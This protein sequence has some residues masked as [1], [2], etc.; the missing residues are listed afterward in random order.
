MATDQI[1]QY[2]PDVEKIRLDT[3]KFLKERG[4]MQ[5]WLA[6][7]TSLSNCSISLFIHSKRILVED[8][9]DI[10]KSIIY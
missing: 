5:S 4:T 3:I 8:K 6:A 1:I 2:P 9:L 10:I 7:K